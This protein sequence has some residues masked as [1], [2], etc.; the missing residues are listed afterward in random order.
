M[1]KVLVPL[2]N[3]ALLAGLAVTACTDVP[4]DDE[5][6]DR[7]LFPARGVIRGTVTYVG[8]RPC[9]RDGHIVGSAIVLV[10]D[11]R[12]PPPPAGIATSALNFVAVPGDVL[13]SNEPRS[14]AHELTCP[15]EQ[16]PVTVSAPFTIS[17]LEGGSYI[18]ASFYDRRGRFRPTFGFR[19][20][21]EAGDIGGGYVDLED[22]RKNAGNPAHPPRYLPV[23]VGTPVVAAETGEITDYRIGENGHVVDNVPVT[24]GS[25][26]P[27]TRPTFH[28]EGAEDVGVAVTSDANP[29][30][31]PLAVP[32]LAMTEDARILAPPTTP[33]PETLAAYQ[34]SFRSLK[35]VWG[36]AAD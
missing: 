15:P 34:A 35:L 29:T 4:I 26:V 31:N 3:L 13:F 27:F 12:N 14:L 2:R 28:P 25:V 33:T 8:P 19:N 22:A 24:L 21:P 17:P 36:V 32:I 23:D 20:L 5:R 1:R 10:F 11:R 6:S 9:S 18:L 7:R 16:P 30:G